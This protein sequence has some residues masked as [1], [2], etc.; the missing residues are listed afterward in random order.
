MED[1]QGLPPSP[2][3][4]SVALAVFAAAIVVLNLWTWVKSSDVSYLI[5]AAAFAALA[6]GFY[7]SPIRFRKSF[8][9]NAEAIRTI[10]QPG[11]V[12]G[13]TLA[14]VALLLASLTLRWLS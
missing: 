2:P 13:S 5:S 11:W 9:A 7:F 1:S 8:K 10:K 14:G 12:T 3:S 6:P 4:S